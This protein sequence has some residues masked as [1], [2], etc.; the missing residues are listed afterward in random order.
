MSWGSP[1]LLLLPFKEDALTQM[2]SARLQKALPKAN[3]AAPEPGL[4]TCDLVPLQHPD[5]TVKWE[6]SLCDQGH[7]AVCWGNA[8]LAA[9]APG[10]MAFQTLEARPPLLP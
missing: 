10:G 9:R 7:V 5:W 6:V 8:G 3:S 4:C 2:K 1:T